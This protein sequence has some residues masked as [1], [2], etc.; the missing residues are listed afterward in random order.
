MDVWLVK[1]QNECRLF[2]FVFFFLLLAALETK[3]CAWLW[4]EPR[5]KRWYRNLSLMLISKLT[6]RVVFP[7]LTISTAWI[8]AQKGMGYFNQNPAPLI[9]TMILSMVLIDL[10]MYLQHLMMHRITLFWRMHRVHHM[11]RQ[12]DISTGLRFHPL[13]EIFTMG[14]K[15]LA[16]AFIGAPVVAVLLYEILLNAMTMFAHMNVYIKPKVDKILRWLI[17]TPNMHRTHHSDYPKETNSNYGFCLSIWDRAFGTYTV[18]PI[19]G[20]RRITVGLED[21]QQSY[22]QTVPNLLLNPFN[23]R[24][25]KVRHPKRVPSRMHTGFE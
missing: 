15:L 9:V 17:I 4:Q 7:F 10:V 13:E 20:E 12:L 3:Y 14:F 22:F 2:A 5:R 6:I 11:D 16:V 21:Y 8:A 24:S 25:L 18:F 1:H 19:T 23:P